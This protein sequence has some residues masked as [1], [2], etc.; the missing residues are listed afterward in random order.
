MGDVAPAAALLLLLLPRPWPMTVITSAR[1]GWTGEVLLAAQAR[2]L[3]SHGSQQTA[4]SITSHPPPQGMRRTID[5]NRSPSARA[6]VMRICAHSM[7]CTISSSGRGSNPR[8]AP[9]R[10]GGTTLRPPLRCQP[11]VNRLFVRLT[12]APVAPTRSFAKLW[13]SCASRRSLWAA[14]AAELRRRHR[15]RRL[16]LAA[17]ATTVWA[18]RRRQRA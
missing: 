1:G 9:W 6:R 10:G 17:T 8:T 18:V 7:P 13:R 16:A 5:L 14:I 4:R 15:M 11:P 2:G 12:A 3:P